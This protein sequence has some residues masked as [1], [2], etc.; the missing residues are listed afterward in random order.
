MSRYD[1]GF[2]KAAFLNHLRSIPE[3]S[4]IRKTLNRGCVFVLDR[5]DW[6]LSNQQEQDKTPQIEELSIPVRLNKEV[7][8]F[9]QQFFRALKLDFNDWAQKELEAS[10][11]ALLDQIKD[12]SIDGLS[13]TIQDLRDQL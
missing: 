3:S 6:P 10:L 13:T 5:G 8:T 9:C 7:T 11:S 12:L 4:L 2:N 1:I